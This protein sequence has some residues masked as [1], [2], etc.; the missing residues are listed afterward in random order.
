MNDDLHAPLFPEESPHPPPLYY[1]VPSDAQKKSR[2]WV[3]WLSHSVHWMTPRSKM[4]HTTHAARWTL[5]VCVL[6][7]FASCVHLLHLWLPALAVLVL[8]M[9]LL[10]VGGHIVQTFHPRDID[11][12]PTHCD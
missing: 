1:S 11:V 8:H 2:A 3:Q 5:H 6:F 7:F 4:I 10:H 9:A 12:T